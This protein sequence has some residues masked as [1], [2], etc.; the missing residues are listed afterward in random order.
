MP[1]KATALTAVKVR[2]AQ[3]GRYGDGNG[4]FLLVRPNGRYWLFRYR[5]GDG[6]MREMGLGP[7]GEAQG[8]VTLADARKAASP[9]WKAVKEGIDPLAARGAEAAAEKAAAQE[10]AARAI[11]F[12][13]VAEHFITAHE[14][15]WRNPKHRAQWR[16]T[17]ETYAYPFM[18]DLP[19]ADVGTAHVLA[20]LEPIWREK[21]ETAT[22]VRGRIEAVLDYAKAREWRSGENPARWRGH[23]DHLLPSRAKVAKVV[24]HAALPWREIGAFMAAL[25][26]REGIAARALEFTILTAAR[27]GE[28]LGATWGEMDLSAALWTAPA[29][30]MKADKE[31]RVPLSAPALALLGEMAKLRTSDDPAAPIFPGQEAD[32]P[33]SNMA[34]LMALRRMGRSDLTAH[35]FRSTFRDWVGEAT[36]YP[37][38]VAEAALAHTQG[39]K[40]V[41]AYARG[42]LF[43]KRRRLMADWGE[44]CGQTTRRS[45]AMVVPLRHA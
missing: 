5:T 32:R 44:F 14:A 28:A 38:D 26:G 39:D 45:E 11:T 29:A 12:R 24:H 4:L 9:L 33:L 15:G 37:A 42:D 23:L 36:G 34:L 43:D 16:T 22:R 1:R 41:A 31:H 40:T 27:T 13:T 3:P 18:R 2:T 19:A 10:A 35:G 25:R 30:R 7:A 6:R 20:A 17:L 21:P 8:Q